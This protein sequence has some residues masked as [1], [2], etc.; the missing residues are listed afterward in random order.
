MK[1]LE[2]ASHHSGTPLSEILF[3]FVAQHFSNRFHDNSDSNL[4]AELEALRLKHGEFETFV[5]PSGDIHIH[6]GN[7][8]HS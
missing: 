7:P 6:S 5:Q 1:Q 4:Q 2:A 8:K 3:R